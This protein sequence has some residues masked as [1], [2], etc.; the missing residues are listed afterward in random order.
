VPELFLGKSVENVAKVIE[1]LLGASVVNALEVEEV[2][3]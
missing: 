2:A 3:S 1:G